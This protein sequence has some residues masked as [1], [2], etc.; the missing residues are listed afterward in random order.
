MKRTKNR[1]DNDWPEIKDV[2]GCRFFEGEDLD[3]QARMQYLK[4]KQLEDIKEGIRAKRLRDQMDKQEEADWAE[5]TDMV[6]RMRGMLE[7]ENSDK[8]YNKEKEIQEENIRLAL[9]KKQK[10]LQE[11][12]WHEGMNANETYRD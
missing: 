8:R 1:H 2:S 4:D 5:Q 3:Y 12:E 11:K 6:T 7:D 9:L 10:E